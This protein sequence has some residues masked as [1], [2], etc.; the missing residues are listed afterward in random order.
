MDADPTFCSN[1]NCRDSQ[2]TDV[3]KVM[4]L[5]NL[6]AARHLVANGEC[7]PECPH[8]CDHC[9]R[10]NYCDMTSLVRVYL[11]SLVVIFILFTQ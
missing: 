8:P 5:N 10:I 3:T 7:S 2:L 6:N 1:W 4:I 11:Q 9:N